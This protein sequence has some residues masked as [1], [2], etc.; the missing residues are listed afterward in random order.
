M[1]PTAMLS[2]SF[3]RLFES[4]MLCIRFLSVKSFLI[5]D[6]EFN[7]PA[8]VWCVRHTFFSRSMSQVITRLT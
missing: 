2:I 6:K 4:R 3:Q 5:L 8:T 7:E 1:W